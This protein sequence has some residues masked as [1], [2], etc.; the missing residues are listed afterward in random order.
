MNQ[1]DVKFSLVTQAWKA[2]EWQRSDLMIQ[3]YQ[4][5]GRLNITPRKRQGHCLRSAGSVL[6]V[7][8]AVRKEYW[9][10]KNRCPKLREKTEKASLSLI[11][12]KLKEYCCFL[13]A[14][15]EQS[16]HNGNQTAW[17]NISR[18]MNGDILA[19]STFRLKIRYFPNTRALS[20]CAS[21]S[22]MNSRSWKHG[23][24]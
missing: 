20:F 6:K 17:K 5:T 12:W 15:Q 1:S 24:L 21:L 10:N 13:Y 18:W 8:S 2:G 16:C 4:Y 7:Q 9:D 11:V 3:N 19:V 23:W 22:I 14:P